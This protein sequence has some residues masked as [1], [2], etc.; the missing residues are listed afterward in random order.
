M[1][2]VSFHVCRRPNDRSSSFFSLASLPASL[3]CAR[4]Y[5]RLP[6]SGGVARLLGDASRANGQ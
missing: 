6:F 1:L 4:F 5:C 3:Y 2:F